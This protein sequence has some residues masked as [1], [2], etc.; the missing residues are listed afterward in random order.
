LNENT[1]AAVALLV[2]FVIGVVVGF[3]GAF[4]VVSMMFG[5]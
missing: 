1:R 4:A 5:P 3:G 2:G